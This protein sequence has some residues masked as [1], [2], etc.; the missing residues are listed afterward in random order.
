MYSLVFPAFFL[1]LLWAVKIF[2][3]SME[4]SFMEGGVYPRKIS[5]L[6]GILFS[7]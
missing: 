5:G 4:V 6:K 1:F 3:I 2:E 7:P